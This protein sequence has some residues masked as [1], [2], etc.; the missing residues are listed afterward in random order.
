MLSIS[1]YIAAVVAGHLAWYTW[2]NVDKVTGFADGVPA[3]AFFGGDAGA[4]VRAGAQASAFTLAILAIVC[5]YVL[6]LTIA[7]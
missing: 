7:A 1:F 2:R 3:P 6:L 5:A 4:L